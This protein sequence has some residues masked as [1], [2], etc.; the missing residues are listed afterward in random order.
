[1]RPSHLIPAALL[2][3]AGLTPASAADLT[4]ID[5]SLTDEP[6]YATAAP[7]YCL[8][9]FGAEAK[10][11]VWL[12]LDG[13]VLHVRASP[14]G[15]AAPAWRQFKNARY[16]AVIGDVWEEGGKIRHEGLRYSPGQDERTLSVR[17]GGKT[18]SA[19]RDP[20]GELAFAAS[21]KD[22]PVVHFNGPLTLDLFYD[23]QPLR[24]GRVIDMTAVVGTRGLGPGTFAALAVRAYPRG[25]WPT[26]VIE[27]PAKDGGKPIVATVRLADD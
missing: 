22:A 26:A 15:K 9:T 14:D 3:V 13:D 4:K 27:Y 1:M 16:G 23:Q 25:A 11:L 19:G 8:L 10:T 7:K 12:V 21:A 6:K 5:R 20:R 2:V 17:V 24:S 18:Q